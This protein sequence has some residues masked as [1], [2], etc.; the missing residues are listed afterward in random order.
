MNFELRA[1]TDLANRAK[2]GIFIYLIVW[3]VTAV[4]AGMHD[5]LP[6]V[7]YLNLFLLLSIALLRITHNKLLMKGNKFNTVTMYYLLVGLL[8]FSAL[9]W[10]LLTTWI[11]F[12][13]EFPELKYPY[14]IIAAAFAMGGSA[15]LSISRLVGV[16]YPILIYIPNMIIGFVI[17]DGETIVM[18]ALAG[19]SLI[20]IF[21]A[22]RATHYDYHNSI[23]NQKLAEERAVKLENQTKIDSLTGLY[24]RLY[25]NEQYEYEWEQAKQNKTPL[26]ILMLDLDYFKAINDEFG[27][28]MGDE[29]LKLAAEVLRNNVTQQ[30][31]TICRFGG[32]EFV[33][34]LPN[35]HI[36]DAAKIADAIIKT[37]SEKKCSKDN[38]HAQLTS[39]IGIAEETPIAGENKETI[40]KMADDALYQAKSHGRNRYVLSEA[41]RYTIQNKDGDSNTNQSLSK[42][43]WLS[44]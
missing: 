10:G 35:T 15:V 23:I 20:Y 37:F 9:H 24:N 33:V 44:E 27:H 40:L 6:S 25:F 29:C 43:S 11:L 5:K 16:V 8:L 7:F 14:M 38:I 12:S 26:S 13:G 36:H 4:W 19:V 30:T 31:D 34:I 18:M 21:V 3:V 22:S 2:G 39:S 32:E 17:G 41:C 28:L 42:K 1:H